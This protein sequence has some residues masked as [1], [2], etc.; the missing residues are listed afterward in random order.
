MEELKKV[1]DALGTAFEEYK[2]TNDE[3]FE[4]LKKGGDAGQHEEKL[5]KLEADIKRFG[6]EKAALEAKLSRPGAPDT[7]D[8]SDVEYRKAFEG[9]VRKG[10]ISP[11]L[12][13]DM[14]TGS[15]PDGGYAVPQEMSR[16]IYSLLTKATP[17]RGVCRVISIGTPDYKE[18]V[19]K[20]GSTSG[21]VGESDPR[22]KTDTPQLDEVTPYMGEI[23]ANPAATQTVL[24]D[25][26]F[27]VEQFL[28]A[29]VATEFSEKENEA[30][31]LGDGTKKPMGFLAYPNADTAD[32]TRAFGTLQFIATGGAA[33]FP[34]ANPGDILIDLIHAL[35]SGHRTAARFMMANLTLA[36]IRKWKDSDGN[37][38]WQPGLQQGVPSLLL[39]YLVTENEDMPA[40]GANALA[41]AFG[42][43]NRG[44]TIVDR[45]GVSMLRDPYTAKP[46]VTFYTRKRVGGFLKDSEAIKL[47]K[48]A[49]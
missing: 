2:K 17:M 25:V 6:E 24:E 23:Y 34:T 30:F 13:K 3:R 31:T 8:V 26:F 22:P 9:F 46:F 21:W 15:D 4:E 44:Y 10:N 45:V 40:V 48:C 5:A 19:N 11:E 29:E 38:L 32:G 18:L 1:L 12:T 37:Y 7:G 43:F 42:D 33:G 49:A 16:E 36:A 27:N 41:V 28:A 47:L 14:T 35:K 20:H 39:G